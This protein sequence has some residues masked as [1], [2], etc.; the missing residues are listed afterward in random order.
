MGLRIENMEAVI[1][2]PFMWDN[3]NFGALRRDGTLCAV[4]GEG[5]MVCAAELNGETAVSLKRVDGILD[6]W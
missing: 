2:H 1:L 4:D 3:A 5:E 6:S